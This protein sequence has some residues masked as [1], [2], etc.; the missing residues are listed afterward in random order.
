MPGLCSH[1]NAKLVCDVQSFL[2]IVRGRFPCLPP[3]KFDDMYDAFSLT[4]WCS[5]MSTSLVG[6]PPI[7]GRIGVGE[8]TRNPLTLVVAHSMTYCNLV[9]IDGGFVPWDNSYNM[10]KR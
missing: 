10:L 6:Y 4:N 1:T 2:V 8:S 9:G 5:L 3:L 7:F